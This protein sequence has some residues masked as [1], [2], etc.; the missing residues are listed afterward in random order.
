M[1]S[2]RERVLT[3]VRTEL[4]KIDSSGDFETRLDKVVNYDVFVDDLPALRSFA[5]VF[6]GPHESIRQSEMCWG[7]A[8]EN[9]LQVLIRCV[10]RAARETARAQADKLMADIERTIFDDK[11][12]GVPTVEAYN[13]TFTAPEPASEAELGTVRF[14]AQITVSWV[15]ELGIP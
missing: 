5:G 7:I 1:A 13:R 14:L 6:A 3:A 12:L 9:R 11:T 10:V 8:V 4:E 2:T 15:S